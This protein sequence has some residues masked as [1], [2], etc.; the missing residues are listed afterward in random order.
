MYT[1]ILPQVFAYPVNT[2]ILKEYN[3]H[4]NY[5]NYIV[6][7]HANTCTVHVTNGKQETNNESAN[8]RCTCMYII[9]C[10]GKLECYYNHIV[11]TIQ[12]TYL[13]YESI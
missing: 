8:Y 10:L 5:D 12:C 2:R 13:Q 9:I 7:V 11:S 3:V 4:N 1:S 6:N